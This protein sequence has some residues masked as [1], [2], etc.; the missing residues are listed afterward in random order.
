MVLRGFALWT[1]W[2]W[3]TRIWNIVGDDSRSAGFKVVHI[4]LAAV[5]VAFAVATWIIVARTAQRDR[6][7]GNMA[8]SAAPHGEGGADGQTGRFERVE[9]G[10]PLQ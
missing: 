10:P 7:S 1:L 5:S 2:V 8:S 3:G 4:V 6:V 9:G